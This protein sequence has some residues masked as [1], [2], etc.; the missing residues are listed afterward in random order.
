[1]NR[2][3]ERAC[4]RRKWKGKWFEGSRRTDRLAAQEMRIKK[5]I[6]LVGQLAGVTK[7]SLEQ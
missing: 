5:G 6:V 3:W 2:E 1:M 7:T 4:P